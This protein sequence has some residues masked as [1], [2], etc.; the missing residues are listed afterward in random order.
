MSKVNKKVFVL[1]GTGFLGYYVLRALDEAGLSEQGLLLHDKEQDL[2]IPYEGYKTYI[3]NVTKPT[4]LLRAMNNFRPDVVINLVGIIKENRPSATFKKIHVAGT[5]NL[6]EAAKQAGVKKII[7]VSSI[8]ADKNGNTKFFRTKAA[9]EEI[10]K[11][12]GLQYTIFRPTMMF[13]WKS[14]LTN[15]LAERSRFLPV[16]PLIGTGEYKMQPVAASVTAQAIAQA[17]G[18]KGENQTYDVA[19]PETLTL[20]EVV[21]RAKEALGSSKP[22]VPVPEFLVHAGAKAAE[23]GLPL[24]INE[25]QFHLL[26]EGNVGDNAALQ[27]EFEVEKI[28]FDPNGEYPLY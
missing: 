2:N 11:S 6:I 4:T 16:I 25:A 23:L 26:T 15:G 27:K 22:I 13:G 12:S 17:A 1:G 28:Y 8:G 18:E 19:G 21:K 7:Y 20:R 10:V 24:P 14:G 5:R 9:A 3:G